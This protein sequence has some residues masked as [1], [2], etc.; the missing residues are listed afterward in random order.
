MS[1]DTKTLA[2]FVRERESIRRKKAAGRRPPWTQDPILNLYKFTNVR[3][4]DDRVSQWL[5]K[6]VLTEKN[7][8]SFGLE[9]FLMFTAFCRFVNWPPTI[10]AMLKAIAI[11][12]QI[13]MRQLGNYVDSLMKDSDKVWSGA[14]MVRG[15][16]PEEARGMGKAEFIATK[17]V[18][19][20]MKAGMGSIKAAINSK[21]MQSANEV[22]SDLFGFGTFMGGQTVCDWSYTSLLRDAGDRYAWAPQGPGSKRGLNR[23]LKRPIDTVIPPDEWL[24]YLGEV[25]HVII[26]ELG[27]EFEDL[28]AQSCQSVLCECDKFLRAKLGEGRP[29]SKY[30]PETAF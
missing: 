6:N 2:Y 18:Q 1:L 28:D 29:R 26:S 27:P 5:I 30:K 22:I 25:R 23:L 9:Y 19:R 14:Y 13:D 8:K 12:K 21:S 10:D 3:R 17:V 11:E 20:P 7:I 16:R 24:Q 4:E 15:P